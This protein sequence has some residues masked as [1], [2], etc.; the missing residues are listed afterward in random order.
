[1]WHVR[2]LT[3]CVPEMELL[4][5][6]S[7]GRTYGAT[8]SP[9]TVHSLLISG[10]QLDAGSAIE[11]MMLLGSQLAKQR[12]FMWAPQPQLSVG[13]RAPHGFP[14]HLLC[15]YHKGYVPRER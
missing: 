2:I 13:P 9:C 11:A 10:A 15:A 5:G 4:Q 6:Y 1:M 12:G 7:P 14:H 8:L 3:C